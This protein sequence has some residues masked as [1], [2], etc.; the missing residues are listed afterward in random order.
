LKVITWEILA[1][2]EK[3]AKSI[4]KNE[5]FFVIQKSFVNLQTFLKEKLM[6]VA[7]NQ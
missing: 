7:D 2:D 6:L 3:M 5:Y 1:G 4:K